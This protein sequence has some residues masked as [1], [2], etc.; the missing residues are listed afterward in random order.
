VKYVEPQVVRV[1]IKGAEAH[2]VYLV[3]HYGDEQEAWDA[4]KVGGKAGKG[5]LVDADECG[6]LGLGACSIKI[7]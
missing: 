4:D 6:N 1:L 7:N 3:W 5:G 2:W